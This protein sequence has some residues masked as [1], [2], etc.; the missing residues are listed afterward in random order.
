MSFLLFVVFFVLSAIDAVTTYEVIHQPGGKELNPFMRMMM[1]VF[2]NDWW[3]A[4]MILALGIGAV[5]ASIAPW[6][7]L[8]IVCLGYIGVVVFNSRSLNN[9]GS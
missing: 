5:L 6:W 2:G 9:F 8:G 7:V 3:I 1:R 4:K